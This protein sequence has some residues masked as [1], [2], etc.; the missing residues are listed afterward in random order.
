MVQVWGNKRPA[1]P[2]AKAIIHPLEFA[3]EDSTSKVN[4]LREEMSKKHAGAFVASALDEV[5]CNKPYFSHITAL[6][7]K[8]LMFVVV[9]VVNIRALKYSWK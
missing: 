7:K 8:Q 5:A 9:V 2:S 6:S 3:G 1:P 4:K